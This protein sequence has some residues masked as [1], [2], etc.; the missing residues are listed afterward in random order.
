MITAKTVITV[1]RDDPRFADYEKAMSDEWKKE[2]CTVSVTWTRVQ[3]I[4]YDSA[5][6]KE[7]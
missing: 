1:S 6:R 3:T 5:E 7:E 2:E 4:G